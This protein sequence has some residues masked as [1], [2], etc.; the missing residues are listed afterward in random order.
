M[1]PQRWLGAGLLV[2][3]SVRDPL[4]IIAVPDRRGRLTDAEIRSGLQ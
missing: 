2:L 3:P 1:C 4:V